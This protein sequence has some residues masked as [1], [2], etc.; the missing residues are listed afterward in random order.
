MT[1][2]KTD[3]NAYDIRGFLGTMAR[4]MKS[5]RTETGVVLQ[6]PGMAAAEVFELRPNCV[7]DGIS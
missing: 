7:K 6:M 4:R 2:L 5:E 1:N 3:V